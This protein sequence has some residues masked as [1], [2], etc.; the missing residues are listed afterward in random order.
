MFRFAPRPRD[1]AAFA[2]WPG[3]ARRVLAPCLFALASSA[4]AM[5]VLACIDE[6]A[7]TPDIRRDGKGIWTGAVHELVH[8]AFER[9]G[10]S[11]SVRPLPWGRC[12]KEVEEFSGQAGQ[13]ELLFAASLSEERKRVYLPSAPLLLK[14]NGVWYLRSK[15]GELA[16]MA[17]ISDLNRF[18]LCGRLNH[19]HQWLRDQGLLVRDSGAPSLN[20]ALAKLQLG[21]CDMVLGSREEVL[22]AE[23]SGMLAANPDRRF[24]PFPG[25]GL[26][27]HYLLW[28]RTSPRATASV[29]RLNAALTDLRADGTAAAIFR[30]HRAS[31]LPLPAKLPAEAI[32]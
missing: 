9:A 30:R 31:S 10:M 3:F 21:R 4:G 32:R 11:L 8:A 23:A 28:A 5:P 1:L 20:S 19:N 29:E 6:R 13:V 17:R 27:A 7:D 26:V 24:M 12:L 2:S 25:H 14:H 16:P 22:D 18:Q 15:L